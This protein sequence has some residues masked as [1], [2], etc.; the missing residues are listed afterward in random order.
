[1]GTNFV[2]ISE[3]EI[4]VGRLDKGP[5]VVTFN[6]KA[7]LCLTYRHHPVLHVVY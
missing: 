6:E 2:A 5:G 4:C 3:N 7:P 1:M